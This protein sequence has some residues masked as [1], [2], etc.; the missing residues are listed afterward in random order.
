MLLHGN[1]AKVIS[2]YDEYIKKNKEWMKQRPVYGEEYTIRNR[3]ITKEMK[4]KMKRDLE[5][6]IGYVE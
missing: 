2:T 1:P 3:N 5:D 4:E 6:G